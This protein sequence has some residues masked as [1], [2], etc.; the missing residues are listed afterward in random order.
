MVS[1]WGLSWSAMYNAMDFAQSLIK[2]KYP[3]DMVTMYSTEN[4]TGRIDVRCDG[5]YQYEIVRHD[6]HWQCSIEVIRKV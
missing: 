6:G 4:G 5:K 2:G 1:C 3:C